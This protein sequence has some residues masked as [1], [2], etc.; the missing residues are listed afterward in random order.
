MWP[1]E[2]YSNSNGP[3]KHPL[4]IT[5]LSFPPIVP[6]F[7]LVLLI[8]VT[9]L[10]KLKTFTMDERTHI[11]LCFLYLSYGILFHLMTR[12]VELLQITLHG[13]YAIVLGGNDD[14]KNGLETLSSNCT[15]VKV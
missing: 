4:H 9:P 8:L 10:L 5:Y 6:C 2:K 11:I 3:K 1:H 7:F 13:H 15:M 12:N 14:G